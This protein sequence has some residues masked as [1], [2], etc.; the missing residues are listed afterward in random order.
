[1]K[2]PISIS[3]A[4][5]WRK[6]L[7]ERHNELTGLRNQN[8]VLETRYY[9]A[10]VDKQRIIEPLYDAVALDN[11]ISKMGREIRVLDEAVK[12]TNQ[13]TKVLDYERDDSV[14]G[15]LVPAKKA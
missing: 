4:L 7:L 13:V 10:N 15:E 3:V 8:A 1:M 5:G 11:L 14:L 2:G 9:G 12:Q 6:T